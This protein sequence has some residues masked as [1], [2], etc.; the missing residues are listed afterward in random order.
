MK[1]IWGS[2]F[3]LFFTI[4]YSQVSGDLGIDSLLSKAQA[5]YK[6][7][8]D[9]AYYYSNIAHIK[10]ISLKDTSKIAE[11]ITYKTTYMLS[12][13]K[14]DEA[15]V[16]LQYNLNHKH[17]I[18]K[19]DL[20]ITYNNL[21]ALYALREERDL[22]LVNYLNAI[23]VFTETNNHSFLARNYLN[24]G[25][26]YENEGMLEL[27]DYFYDKSL[28]HSKLSK[29]KVANNLHETIELESP[30]DFETKQ[31]ISLEA[32]KSI[33]NPEES[34]LAAVIYHDLSKNY[35]EN[36]Q[37]ED[38]IRSAKKAIKIKNNIGYLQNLDFSY[39]ILGKS[40]VRLNRN[41]EG[42]KNLETAISLSEKRSLKQL[43]YEMVILGHKNKGDFKSA[44]DYTD[45]LNGIK[46]S[47]AVFQENER[48]AEITAQ[49]ETDKQAQEIEILEADNE[50]KQAQ[51]SNQKNILIA[52][53]IG[54]VL[55]LLSLF[56]AYKNHKTKQNLQFSELTQKLLQMQLNPHF[57]FNALNGIQ[58]FI[59]KN[60]VKKSTKY[61]SSFSGLMRNI[62]ENSVEKFI[63]IQEDH[64]TIKDFLE[65]QQLVNNNSFDYIIHVDDS[66]DMEHM[67]VPPM[68]TQPFVE[69]AIIHGVANLEEGLIEVKYKLEGQTIVVEIVDNGKGISEVKTNANSLHKSMGTSI[70]KQR[71][72]NLLKMER[73]PIELEIVSNTHDNM[74]HGTKVVLS[75]PVKYM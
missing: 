55:L 29:N 58:Y 51:L 62:L 59:K 17:L 57:L 34:R 69:N 16:L 43:M 33:K 37:Y 50:L 2:I 19:K 24:A 67:C 70:T 45:R 31:R 65:L 27:A 40:Q 56:F 75:F 35:I 61:I 7:N 41:E 46:D 64:D 26:I 22:A 66:L 5:F 13:K 53:G 38:A 6:T 54:L 36:R 23:D 8:Q 25:V 10:A 28:Y 68:F 71:M 73:Y 44:L 60:D 52:S 14:Y 30:T 48:I 21:G 32:L 12:L 18:T 72:D 74:E 39:F 42:I 47:I 11:A 15:L 20:G 49:F 1:N 4:G 63:S 3:L 9:S